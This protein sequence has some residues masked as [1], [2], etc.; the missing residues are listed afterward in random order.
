MTLS[1]YTFYWGAENTEFCR[2]KNMPQEQGFYLQNRLIDCHKMRRTCHIDRKMA[3]IFQ[4]V[5]A[6]LHSIND[7]PIF[8]PFDCAH[9]FGQI[10]TL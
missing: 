9:S 6:F 7:A 1:S 8:L 2:V 4:S 3:L 5:R 10:V